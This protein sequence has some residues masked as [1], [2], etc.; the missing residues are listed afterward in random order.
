MP[1]SAAL[2]TSQGLMP[3]SGSSA[4]RTG[5]GLRSSA[6]AERAA[7]S[8]KSDS[9]SGSTRSPPGDG[10]SLTTPALLKGDGAAFGGGWDSLGV[11]G[12]AVADR[13]DLGAAGIDD[14]ESVAAVGQTIAD[15]A[16]QDS[17][18]VVWRGRIAQ[19]G[20]DDPLARRDQAEEIGGGD[21]VGERPALEVDFGVGRVHDF[22]PFGLVV[23]RIG[24]EL[25][26][27]DS[28]AR[29]RDGEFGGRADFGWAGLPDDGRRVALSAVER[30]A[31]GGRDNFV[32]GRIAAPGDRV[33]DDV[34]GSDQRKSVAAVGESVADAPVG[35]DGVCG[36]DL[37]CRDD[38]RAA[39]RDDDL[40]QR[41][42]LG[43]V[44]DGPAS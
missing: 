27:D 33:D 10:D 35:D 20:E 9:S 37:R 7:F 32:V 38:N 4:M 28:A 39:G 5:L 24:H 26:Q 29:E 40:R 18:V 23:G 17:R 12:V 25:G 42:R 11:V 43:V 44:S 34:A 8:A 22:D 31:D 6:S 14:C 13:V 2:T 19:G 41:I 3:L 21:A 1:A 15:R 30:Y 36:V 16:I